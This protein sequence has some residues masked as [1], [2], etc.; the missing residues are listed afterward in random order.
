M[1][2]DIAQLTSAQSPATVAHWLTISTD[3]QRD[4]LTASTAAGSMRKNDD[5]KF[6]DIYKY[7]MSY[8]YVYIYIY[9]MYIKIFIHYTQY[10]DPNLDPIF[11]SGRFS[12][13]LFCHRT[14][15]E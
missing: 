15:K 6:M 4:D 14:H 1:V 5:T 10:F 3:E 12:N 11:A 7:H 9:Y 8:M 13:K 2:L